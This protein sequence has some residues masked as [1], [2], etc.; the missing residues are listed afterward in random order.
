[1]NM[2]SNGGGS[3]HRIYIPRGVQKQEFKFQVSGDSNSNSSSA[4]VCCTKKKAKLNL[5]RKYS[6][7]NFIYAKLN[8][9]SK[10]TGYFSFNLVNEMTFGV[11][12]YLIY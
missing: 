10:V 9:S 7:L 6:E 5:E 8:K 4:S 1:M 12:E 11:N 3:T 2:N